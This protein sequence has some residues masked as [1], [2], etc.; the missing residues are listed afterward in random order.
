MQ[1]AVSRNSLLCTTF[2]APTM[3][4]IF[5]CHLLEPYL[6]TRYIKIYSTFVARGI[7]VSHICEKLY[8]ITNIMF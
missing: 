7:K 3:L 8:N 6:V 5:E 4:L 1:I 2:I